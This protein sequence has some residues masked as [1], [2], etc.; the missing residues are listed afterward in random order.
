MKSPVFPEKIINWA[1]EDVK[2]MVYED[3]LVYGKTSRGWYRSWLRRMDF[4]LF[5]FFV[6]FLLFHCTLVMSIVI[7]GVDVD[8]ASFVVV[9]VVVVA[10]D[11]ADVV[12]ADVVD[13][14]VVDADVVDVAVVVIV[15][16]TTT[17]T[18]ATLAHVAAT[19]DVVPY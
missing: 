13:A 6:Y 8:D 15:A 10:I 7:D 19:H 4:K 11:V 18:G 2:G 12:V 9:V 1:A 5:M 3:M 17:A 14:T 16:T